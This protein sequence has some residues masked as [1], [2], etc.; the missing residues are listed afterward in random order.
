MEWEICLNF[1]SW[2]F[3]FSICCARCIYNGIL[4]FAAEIYREQVAMRITHIFFSSSFYPTHTHRMFDII[5][6]II[7]FAPAERDDIYFFFKKR[8]KKNV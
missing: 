3:S 5:I 7:R 6:I 2:K 1:V 4:C 8:K